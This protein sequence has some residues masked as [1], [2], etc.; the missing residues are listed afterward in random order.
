MIGQFG[1]G[2]YSA[3]LVADKVVVTSKN[4]DDD[5]HIWESSA[6]G[7]FLVRS[8]NDPEMTRG[9]KIV[10]YIKV[11]FAGFSAL[12]AFGFSHRFLPHCFQLLTLFAVQEDQTEYLEERRIK[13]IVKKHSQFIGYPIKLVVEKVGVVF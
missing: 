6:G 4:N 13:E 2:F 8:V 1:V 5:C 11:C 12:A 7:S 9:T 3:F 10:M